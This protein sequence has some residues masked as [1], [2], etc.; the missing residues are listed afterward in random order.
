MSLLLTDVRNIFNGLI[1][2][3]LGIRDCFRRITS[4]E[5]S[6]GEKAASNYVFEVGMKGDTTFADLRIP[7]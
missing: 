5:F 2:S 3:V 1:L 6:D 7:I 4:G